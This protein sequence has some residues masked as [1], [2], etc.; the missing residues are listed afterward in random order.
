VVVKCGAEKQSSKAK[1]KPPSGKKAKPVQ[2][3]FGRADMVRDV[4]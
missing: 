4:R 1:E 3:V 2:K